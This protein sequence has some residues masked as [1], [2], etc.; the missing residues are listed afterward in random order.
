MITEII[1]TKGELQN[2]GW[3]SVEDN[4][5]MS[6][7]VEIGLLKS[8]ES[9]SVYNNSQLS[10]LPFSLLSIS[11]L[12]DF[13]TNQFFSLPQEVCAGIYLSISVCLCVVGSAKRELKQRE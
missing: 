2:L 7:P 6:I 5:L 10:V 12:T 3:L 8:L 11:S 9:L 1:Q 13:R 4:N